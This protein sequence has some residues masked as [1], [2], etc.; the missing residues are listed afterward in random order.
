VAAHTETAVRRP[1]F[2]ISALDQF[3]AD[4]PPAFR[5]LGELYGARSLDIIALFNEGDRTLI[6]GD[7]HSGNLFVDSGRAGCYD[8]TVAGRGPGVRD[9]APNVVV[10]QPR[11]QPGRQLVLRFAHV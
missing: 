5:R 3:A 9:V 2:I 8:W 4:M 7:T 10:W 6:H 11:T 1:Q